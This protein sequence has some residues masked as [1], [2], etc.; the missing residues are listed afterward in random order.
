MARLI[1]FLL[2]FIALYYVLTYI[3]RKLFFP[4]K[5]TSQKAEPEELVQ[6]PSCHTYIPQRSAVRKKIAGRV[7]YFCSEECLRKFLKQ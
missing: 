6:D 3:L 1:V 7:L 4:D 2:L 5:R